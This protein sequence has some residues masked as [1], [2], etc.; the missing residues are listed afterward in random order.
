MPAA[1]RVHS[2]P[3]RSAPKPLAPSGWRIHAR[4]LKRQITVRLDEPTIQYFKSL[5]ADAGLPYQALINLYLRDSA[6]HRRRPSIRWTP[7]A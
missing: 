5:A 6:A 2:D 3:G 7:A 4:R 1:L